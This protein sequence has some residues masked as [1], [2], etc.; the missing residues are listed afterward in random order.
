MARLNDIVPPRELCELIPEDEFSDAAF[1]WHYT[2]VTGF[3][4]R[5]SGCEQ[6]SGKEWQLVPSNARRIIRARERG[7]LIFPAPT[8]EE[9]MS[10]L[11]VCGGQIDTGWFCMVINP[12]HWCIGSCERDLYVANGTESNSPEVSALQVWLRING[13]EIKEGGE[14]V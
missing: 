4:C 7:E 10:A 3:V 13:I 1:A 9:I 5:T 6:V 11:A 14:N 8:L 12:E 2:D